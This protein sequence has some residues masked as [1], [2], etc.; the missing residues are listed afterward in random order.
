M[1]YGLK[2]KGPFLQQH[3][4]TP[5]VLYPRC[6]ILTINNNVKTKSTLTFKRCRSVFSSLR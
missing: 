3:L 4:Q 5:I 2:K 1:I 6:L